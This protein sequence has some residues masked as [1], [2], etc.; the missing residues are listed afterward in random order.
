MV[1]LLRK[2]GE[3]VVLAEGEEGAAEGEEEAA[4]EE[5]EAG[6]VEGVGKSVGI[7]APMLMF[8]IQD[9]PERCNA[10]GAKNEV[11]QAVAVLISRGLICQRTS[12]ESPDSL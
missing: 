7:V 11:L 8:D 12:H 4:V 6:A 1:L 5:A 3:M 2:R 10:I 9:T